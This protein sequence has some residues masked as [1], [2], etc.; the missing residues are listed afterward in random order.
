AA[1]PGPPRGG[2][3][4]GRRPVADACRGTAESATMTATPQLIFP[5]LWLI[6]SMRPFSL[7]AMRNISQS[8]GTDDQA[9]CPAGGAPC[10]EC[11]VDCV[12]RSCDS[13]RTL[14]K[15]AAYGR[16]PD[17]ESRPQRLSLVSRNAES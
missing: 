3:E 13:I 5:P 17:I 15:G 6:V 8:P 12:R 10:R 2:V 9:R 16:P 1:E 4:S 11:G 7:P 14:H